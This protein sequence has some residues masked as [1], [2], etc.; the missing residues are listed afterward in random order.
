MGMNSQQR[1][2]G[3]DFWPE[4]AY[5]TKERGG[6]EDR[7]MIRERRGTGNLMFPAEKAPC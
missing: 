5:G 4:M 2:C 6:L 3:Q 7:H 1:V